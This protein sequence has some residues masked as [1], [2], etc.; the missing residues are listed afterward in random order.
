MDGR[1][2]CDP[3]STSEMYFGV[4]LSK[5]HCRVY[6]WG[7]RPLFSVPGFSPWCLSL[8]RMEFPTGHT[9]SMFELKSSPVCGDGNG[10]VWDVCCLHTIPLLKGAAIL[11][12]SQLCTMGNIS[13]K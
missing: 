7:V 9:N 3:V 5:L 2:E 10:S 1:H 13:Y 11:G 12:R 8:R 6:G 4:L